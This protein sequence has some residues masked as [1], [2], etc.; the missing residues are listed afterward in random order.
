MISMAQLSTSGTASGGVISLNR[1]ADR[2]GTAMLVGEVEHRCRIC[3]KKPVDIERV[4]VGL[5]NPI[6]HRLS[7]PQSYATCVL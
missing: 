2:N 3:G 4:R 5:K 6:S 7:T 1:V